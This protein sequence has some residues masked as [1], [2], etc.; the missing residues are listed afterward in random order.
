MSSYLPS[1]DY[2]A[3][4]LEHSDIEDEP[5]GD[6]EDPDTFDL[7]P[8][9]EPTVEPHQ[10]IH[11][12]WEEKSF[13]SKTILE[14]MPIPIAQTKKPFE[15]FSKYFPDELFEKMAKHTKKSLESCGKHH[16]YCSKSLVKT[17]FGVNALMGV[18]KCPQ[19]QFYFSRKFQ[20]GPISS[21]I[22]YEKFRQVRTS[23]HIVDKDNPDDLEKMTNRLWKVQPVIDSVRFRCQQLHRD[24]SHYSIGEQ[25]IHFL[26]P[27]IGTRFHW[28]TRPVGLKNF[29]VTDPEGLVVD[30]EIFQGSLTDLPDRN[31]FGTEAAVVLRLT[32][33][34]PG[35][36]IYFGRHFTTL[37]LINELDKR[38]INAT[39]SITPYRLKKKYE[40]KKDKLMSLGQCQEI[41]RSDGKICSVKWMDS[42]AS[43]T[44]ISTTY[45]S[46]P[47]QRCERYDKVAKEYKKINCPLIVK[48]Y[49]RNILGVSL[50]EQTMSMFSTQFKCKKW[51]VNVILHLFEMSLVNA[52]FEYRAEARRCN[53]ARADTLEAV[54]FRL[55]IIEA[56]FGEN[57]FN[58]RGN[59]IVPC[60][61]PTEIPPQLDPT[62]PSES[63]IYVPPTLDSINTRFDGKDHWLIMDK[64]IKSQRQ[65]RREKCKSRTN[66]M[67]SKCKIYLCYNHERNCFYTFHN[68]LDKKPD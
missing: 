1:D 15:Y 19:K 34:L 4:L 44:L 24:S 5:T 21:R 59:S 28:K 16:K 23:L 61:T 50:N 33:T 2:I 45:G 22:T 42:K 64:S 26:T 12:K 40:F 31:I 48:N 57:T 46:T 9:F 27:R 41:C 56:L 14:K 20:Y 11:E 10:E 51:P 49:K 38:G 35:A 37:P 29:I 43:I 60:P 18:V 65:C 66:N 53:L 7:C 13:Q 36:C 63:S 55:E 62:S 54:S 17:F 68:K 8:D 3:E 52:Y 25:M 58:N 6:F 47:Y 67:C 30:F 39:G 32:R